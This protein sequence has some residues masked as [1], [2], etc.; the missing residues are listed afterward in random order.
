MTKVDQS[1]RGEHDVI[2]PLPGST[3]SPGILDFCLRF[4][5][6]K[7]KDSVEETQTDSGG[8]I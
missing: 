8:C 5:G 4:L 6:F 1:V 2:R 3:R 7:T